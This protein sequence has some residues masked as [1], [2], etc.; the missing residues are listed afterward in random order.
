MLCGILEQ[1]KQISTVAASSV[2]AADISCDFHKEG[3]EDFKNMYKTANTW[4]KHKGVD[5][6]AH[7]CPKSR[8]NW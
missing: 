7:C 3:D 5:F 4:R 2:N 8:P 6:S 1:N